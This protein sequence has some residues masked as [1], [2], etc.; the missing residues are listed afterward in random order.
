MCNL[1][2]FALSTLEE[3]DIGNKSLLPSVGSE[4]HV[5]YKMVSL[6]VHLLMKN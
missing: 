3:A 5:T 2:D 6:S 4:F 1:V